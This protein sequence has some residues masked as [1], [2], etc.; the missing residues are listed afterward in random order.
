MTEDSDEALMMLVA[1]KGVEWLLSVS[2]CSKYYGARVTHERLENDQLTDA[3]MDK[4]RTKVRSLNFCLI[5]ILT[6]GV[7]I[8]SFKTS[9]HVGWSEM[10]HFEVSVQIHNWHVGEHFHLIVG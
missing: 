2:K 4:L 9:N 10:A 7:F 5:L 3:D 1:E 6:F 8:D